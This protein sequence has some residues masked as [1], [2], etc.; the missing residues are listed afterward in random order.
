MMLLN[1][2]LELNDVPAP[3][4]MLVNVFKREQ[5]HSYKKEGISYHKIMRAS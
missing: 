3:F 4:F 2:E 1:Q 5:F